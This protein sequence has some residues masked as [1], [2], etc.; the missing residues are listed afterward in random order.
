MDCDAQK[1]KEAADAAAKKEEEAKAAA[2]PAADAAMR[3]KK[4]AADKAAVSVY[5][6]QFTMPSPPRKARCTPDAHGGVESVEGG[7]GLLW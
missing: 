6:I 4:A 7:G 3:E 5:S 2:A 1:A